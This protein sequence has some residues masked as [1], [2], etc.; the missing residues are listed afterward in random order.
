MKTIALVIALFFFAVALVDTFVRE[1]F[2]NRR[3]P[4]GSDSLAILKAILIFMSAYG[5]AVVAAFQLWRAKL[6]NRLST[7]RSRFSPEARFLVMNYPLLVA[8]ALYG[9][10]LYA[11]GIP[12]R[13][14]FY[15]IG[16]SIMMTLVW[17]IFEFRKT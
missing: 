4:L 16:T 5:F 1:K 15:F 8:P 10:L 2:G 14:F 6:L 12:L 13:E 3:T 11:C 9:Q 7:R 17:A